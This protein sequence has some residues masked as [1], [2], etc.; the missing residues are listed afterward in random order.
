G[1]SFPDEFMTP[2][3]LT[4]IERFDPNTGEYDTLHEVARRLDPAV[5]IVGIGPDSRMVIVGGLDPATG[6]GA[7]FAEVIEAERNTDRQYEKFFEPTLNRTG[8]TATTLSDGR[9]IV[10]G[11][12]QVP[13]PAKSSAGGPS[14]IVGEISVDTGT[15][16]ISMQ[17]AQLAHPRYAHTATRLTDE[18]GAAVLVAGGLDA[19]GKPIKEAE[20]YKPLAED[21]SAQFTATMIVPRWDH[22]AARL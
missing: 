8:L 10:I 6:V 19:M 20:L 17:R 11:G 15:T 9:A 3:A 18:L 4:Q 22:Q 12:Y 2:Q 1:G 21:F 13:D 7:D 14:T 5:A 16:A